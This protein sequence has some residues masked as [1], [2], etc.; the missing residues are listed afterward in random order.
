MTR[1]LTITCEQPEEIVRVLED[2]AVEE[3][4]PFDE[5]VAEYIASRRTSSRV[6]PTVEAAKTEALFEQSVGAV[7]S[8]NRQSCDND[9]IDADLGKEYGRSCYASCPRAV[10]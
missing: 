5:L 8:G 2:R 7:H 10:Q 6:L 3:G 1:K 9:A 4:R